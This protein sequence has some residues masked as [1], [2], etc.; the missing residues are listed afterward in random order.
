MQVK[1][2]SVISG[3]EHTLDLDITTDQLER[4]MNEGIPVEKAFPNLSKQER[5]F[6]LTGITPDEWKEHIA[7][8]EDK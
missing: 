3:K 1:M 8:M 2:K 5:E 4:F 6:L 7:P